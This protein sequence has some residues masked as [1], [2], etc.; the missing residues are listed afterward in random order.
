[1]PAMAILMQ[2]VGVAPV[3]VGAALNLSGKRVFDNMGSR[4]L[5]FVVADAASEAA[6]TNAIAGHVLHPGQRTPVRT[7]AGEPV[8]VWSSRPTVL[9]V[10]RDWLS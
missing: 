6:P 1:M 4:E 9:G 7:T 5:R 8:W 2:A 10:A 3:D